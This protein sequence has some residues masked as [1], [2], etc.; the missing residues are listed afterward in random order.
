MLA[1][2]LLLVIKLIIKKEERWFEL[3][4]KMVGSN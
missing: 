3:S 4:S 2:K 1:L